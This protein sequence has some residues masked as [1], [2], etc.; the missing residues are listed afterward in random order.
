VWHDKS[1]LVVED[2]P[3]IR[4]LLADAVGHEL[5][6]YTVVAPDGAEALV[7]LERLRPTVAVL[8]IALPRMD[9]VEVARRAKADP[10]TRATWLIAISALSPAARV[11]RRALEAGFGDFLPKPLDLEQLLRLVH[12]RLVESDPPAP[13]S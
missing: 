1:V 7:W 12:R 8:D 4:D 9:G 2:D 13:S 3:A 5:G 11:R 10:T 6:A